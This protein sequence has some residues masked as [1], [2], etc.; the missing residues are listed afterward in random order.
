MDVDLRHR[1]GKEKCRG[2]AF[3]DAALSKRCGSMDVYGLHHWYPAIEINRLSCP[4]SLPN[5]YDQHGVWAL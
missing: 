1:A 3:A 4:P 2:S 5:R